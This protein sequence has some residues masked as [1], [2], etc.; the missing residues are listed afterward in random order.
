VSQVRA[1]LLAAG[2][3]A[4]LRPLT[5]ACPKC[6]VPIGGRPLLEYWLCNLHRC[7]ISPVWVNMH[8]HHEMVQAFLLREPFLD[9][10]HGTFEENLLGTAGTL[11]HNARQLEGSTTLLAHADNWCQCDLRKFLEFHMYSRPR[12][13]VMTMMT[14]RTQIPQS[15]GIV[16]V[17]NQGVV[18][19]FVEKAQRPTSNLANGAV[20]L[21]EP[22]VVEWVCESPS[23]TDFSTQVIP[24]FIG[25]I[26][27]WENSEIHR[28]IGVISSLMTAQ[29][30]PQPAPCWPM[31]DLWVQDYLKH[32]VHEYLIN[33]A[34]E[35]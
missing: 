11:R 7:G 16:E 28:D 35:Q 8:Y 2:L 4:R 33:I 13:T 32:P 10:V 27:S 17:N 22:E 5:K 31:E 12:G 1:L 21:L 29:R 24:A 23:V 19:A 30:D 34:R 15:C 9:W 25:R 14:F 18:E 6:L 3:G 26:A 20:Y